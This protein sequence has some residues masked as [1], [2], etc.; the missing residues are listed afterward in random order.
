[1][2]TWVMQNDLTNFLH[3]Q[4]LEYG[5]DIY[6][7]ETEVWSWRVALGAGRDTLMLGILPEWVAA[8][9]RRR[10]GRRRQN[11]ARL[12]SAEAETS[13]EAATTS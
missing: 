10:R 3:I 1:M 7:P 9:G 4:F 5:A 11:R 6:E 8:E 13:A 12:V 2:F